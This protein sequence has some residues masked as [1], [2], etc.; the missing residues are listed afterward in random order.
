[1]LDTFIYEQEERIKNYILSL[2]INVSL[3][4][5]INLLLTAFVHKSY[6]EDFEKNISNNERLEF[7]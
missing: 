6:S 1:M 3:I 4:K 5:N 2:E 7:L